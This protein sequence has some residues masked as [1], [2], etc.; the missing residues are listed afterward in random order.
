LLIVIP[1][2]AMVV[3]LAAPRIFDAFYQ[4]DGRPSPEKEAHR[5]RSS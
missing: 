3:A 5:V 1:I 2:F 4:P